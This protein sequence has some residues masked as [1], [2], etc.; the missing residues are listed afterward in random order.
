[1]TFEIDSINVDIDIDD[2][3]DKVLDTI[4]NSCYDS[5]YHASVCIE[6]IDDFIYDNEDEIDEMVSFVTSQ[7]VTKLS[8]D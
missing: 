8:T 3:V 6:D 7:V 1:M 4:S 2:I 5:I